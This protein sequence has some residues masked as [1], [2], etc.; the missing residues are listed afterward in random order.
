MQNTVAM[1][2]LTALCRSNQGILRQKLSL[3]EV[4]LKQYGTDQAHALFRLTCPIVRA[5]VG[6]HYRHSLDHLEC[7]IGAATAAATQNADHR[8]IHYDL[9]Q[10]GQAD[11]H[12]WDAAL[13]RIHRVSD[14]FENLAVSKDLVMMDYKVG[15]CFMLS[16]DSREEYNLPST[17]ARE[18]GFAAHHAIHH[19]AMVRIIA[20]HTWGLQDS[21]VPSDFGRAPSTIHSERAD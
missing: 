15:A 18:L 14:A 4:V 13:Q 20:I 12:D 10:R 16:G 19:M 3:M 17:I 21:D 1:S 11:E 9:R 2:L 5:S 7:A 8:D 6:Q